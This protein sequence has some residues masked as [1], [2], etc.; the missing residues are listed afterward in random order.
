MRKPAKDRAKEPVA[1]LVDAECEYGN[2]G[3]AHLPCRS[4]I[5]MRQIGKAPRH[6]ANRAAVAGEQPEQADVAERYRHTEQMKGTKGAVGRKEKRGGK[7]CQAEKEKDKI[8]RSL[9]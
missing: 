5:A 3:R 1:R 4:D 2:A 8:G 7:R 9:L 6:A